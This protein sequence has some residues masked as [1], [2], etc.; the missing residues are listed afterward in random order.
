MRVFDDRRCVLGEGPVWHAPTGRV[1][2]VDILSCLIRW[3]SVTDGSTGE[4]EMPSHIGALLPA[5]DGGWVACLVDGVYRLDAEFGS[6]Q[7]LATFP[8]RLPPV[9]GQHR[10]RANDAKVTPGGEVLCGTMPYDWEGQP[11][12]AALYR[13]TAGGLRVLIDGVT[14]SNGMGWSP[15]RTRM[16]YIDTPVGGVDVLD[17]SDAGEVT[18]RRPLARLPEGTGMPDGMAVDAEGGLWVAVWEGSRVQRFTP[19]G[20]ASGQVDVPAARVTSCA[21][22]GPDLRTLIVTTS[23]IGDDSPAA[24]LTYAVDVEV[25]GQPQP[26][27][28]L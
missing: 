21:F 28:L 27:A 4:V 20:A 10:M 12:T 5:A 1:A 7:L 3:R 25:P 8:H 9:D 24:G 2:W 18:G 19:D 26:L 14:I 13:L 6:P 16:Y 23:S 11:G 15:D 22:A 17:V